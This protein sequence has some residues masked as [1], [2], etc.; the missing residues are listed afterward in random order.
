MTEE[1]F[2]LKQ[3]KQSLIRIHNESDSIKLREQISV[4]VL[5]IQNVLPLDEE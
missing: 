1:Q 5:V 2:A 3:I 4:L